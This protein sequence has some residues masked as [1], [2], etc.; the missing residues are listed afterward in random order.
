MYVLRHWAPLG[1]VP[2]R[3]CVDFGGIYSVSRNFYYPYHSCCCHFIFCLMN[4]RS[5]TTICG[6]LVAVILLGIAFWCRIADMVEY[7]YCPECLTGVRIT[8]YCA[9]C[10]TQLVERDEL[11]ITSTCPNCGSHGDTDRK[12]VV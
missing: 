7:K 9:K 2:Y 5:K 12:S 8:S 11:Y 1:S 10:G 4:H 6:M 3:Y